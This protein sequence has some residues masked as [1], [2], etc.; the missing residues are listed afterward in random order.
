[1]DCAICRATKTLPFAAPISTCEYPLWLT[2]PQIQWPSLYDLPTY[3]SRVSSLSLSVQMPGDAGSIQV[4]C[5]PL[6]SMACCREVGLSLH[7]GLWWEQLFQGGKFLDLRWIQIQVC[8]SP[9]L[10]L[11]NHVDGSLVAEIR[12]HVNCPGICGFRWVWQIGYHFEPCSIPG[13]LY[14]LSSI[15]ITS[16]Q[17]VIVSV[18][19]IRKLT[20]RELSIL[21][22]GHLAG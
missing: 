14:T 9:H 7:Q 3:L 5:A 2:K 11:R 1:M 6:L 12:I 4:Q 19:Q 13:I 17:Y 21:P 10:T 18:L 16:L 22:R 8:S 15:I 20:F